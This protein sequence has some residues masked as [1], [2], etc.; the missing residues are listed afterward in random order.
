MAAQREY[1][2]LLFGVRRSV[3]YHDKREGFFLLIGDTADYL[4]FLL[5]A[6]TTWLIVSFKGDGGSPWFIAIFPLAIAAG[7]GIALVL[8]VGS[9]ASRHNALKRR[10]IGLEKKLITCRDNPDANQL[11][12][13]QQE[14]LS[15]E[16]DEPP[17]LRVLDTLC[18][19]ELAYSMGYDDK[20]FKQ[21]SWAQRAFRHFFDVDPESLRAS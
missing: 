9:R 7:R 4:V 18:H 17:V 5:S 13:L 3:R 8:R 11:E 6:A 14:R 19:N 16:A 10:F 20:E 15:I 21:T 12:K 2:D 1:A